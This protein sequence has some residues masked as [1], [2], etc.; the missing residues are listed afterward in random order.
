MTLSDES[1]GRPQNFQ[2]QSRL[3]GLPSWVPDWTHSYEV[4]EFPQLS[5]RAG[6]TGMYSASHDISA[7][8]DILEPGVIA[9]RGIMCG[10]IASVGALQYSDR[11][12][13]KHNYL[14]WS[15]LAATRRIYEDEGMDG[16]W[17]ARF[18][19]CLIGDMCLDEEAG[20]E[21]REGE[22]LNAQ[23]DQDMSNGSAAPFFDHTKPHRRHKWT[24]RSQFLRDKWVMR[25][26]EDDEV[27]YSTS[28]TEEC[29]RIWNSITEDDINAYE[30]Q[31]ASMV[32]GRRFMITNRGEFGLAPGG[33]RPGDMVCV[34]YGGKTPYV[35]RPVNGGVEVT[36]SKRWWRNVFHPFEGV[37]AVMYCVFG[38]AGADM[39]MR[40]SRE[41]PAVRY[42][43]LGDA[44]VEEFMDA[45]AVW[46]VE[47]KR[48]RD[49]TFVLV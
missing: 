8:F 31:V 17:Y 29:Q 39:W 41:R 22:D 33:S 37:R 18:H 44:Y 21:G 23:S 46:Y 20:T 10:K 26:T 13:A 32:S 19:N 2:P 35:L 11:K 15:E 27:L 42:Q 24:P 30:E 34:L 43:V 9:V 28:D 7:S 16:K 48:W 1:L 38:W 3:E 45:R 36:V 5:R 49:R 47:A 4:W 25:F 12:P 14:E 6:Q 40:E